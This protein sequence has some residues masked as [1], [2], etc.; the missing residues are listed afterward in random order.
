MPLRLTRLQISDQIIAGS[1]APTQQFLR[2]FNKAL[3][4]IEEAINGLADAVADIIVA[5]AAADGAAAAAA[6]AQADATQGIADAAAA[7]GDATQALSDAAAAQSTADGKA[8]DGAITGGDLTMSTARLLGRTTAST[9]AI[10]EITVGSGLSLAAGSLSATG[11]GGGAAWALAGT[12]QTATGVYDFAVD[13]AKAAIT[14]AGL[15]TANEIL[16]LAEAVAVS[17]SGSAMVQVSTDNG[18]SYFTTSGDYVAINPGAGTVLNTIGSTFWT[19]N[20]TAARYGFSHI[21]NAAIA[22]MPK[23]FDAPVQ[24]GNPQRL[25]VADNANNID[26]IQ[27]VGTSGGNITAGKIFVLAR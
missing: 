6:A 9:G 20:T 17:V 24:T 12:G 19:T 14:F 8:D 21:M 13:G 15:G 1:S 25:F 27:I 4:K 2:Y 22:G 3:E 10:E 11:G 5:Q 26:A 18:A 16:I 7:Q 23:I